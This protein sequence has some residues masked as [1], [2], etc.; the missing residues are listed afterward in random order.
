ME[1]LLSEAEGARLTLALTKPR[2]AR[3]VTQGEIDRLV[4]WAR[5]VR[6]WNAALDLTLCGEAYLDVNEDGEGMLIRRAEQQ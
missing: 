1:A 6:F 4:E 2:G 3:S 5:Y